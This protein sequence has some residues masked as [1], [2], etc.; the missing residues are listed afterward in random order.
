MWKEKEWGLENLLGRTLPRWVHLLCAWNMAHANSALWAFFSFLKRFFCCVLWLWLLFLGQGLFVRSPSLPQPHLMAML[1]LPRWSLL[2]FLRGGSDIS[3]LCPQLQRI[4]KLPSSPSTSPGSENCIVQAAPG[5][6]NLKA[7]LSPNNCSPQ[8]DSKSH[9][10][11]LLHP[12][13]GPTSNQFL[14]IEF[15]WFASHHISHLTFGIFWWNILFT[16]PNPA[17]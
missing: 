3:Y 13:C 8:M 7:K 1:W 2:C 9:L 10:S 6:S 12:Y 17:P 14:T 4:H 15:K 11:I 5:H 16:Q